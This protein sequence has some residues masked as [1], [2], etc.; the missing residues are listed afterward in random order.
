MNGRK[1]C[2]KARLCFLAVTEGNGGEVG[3]EL[4]N[5]TLLAWAL[6]CEGSASDFVRLLRT[7]APMMPRT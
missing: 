5:A 7:R 4:A 6:P 1:P 3:G 2:A